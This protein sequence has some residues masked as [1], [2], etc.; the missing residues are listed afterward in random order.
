MEQSVVVQ[1][2]L[3]LRK[4]L[5]LLHSF[6]KVLILVLSVH[7]PKEVSQLTSISVALLPV[8]K[9]WRR[10]LL[11]K[12]N[13]LKKISPGK[14]KLVGTQYILRR[15]R[16][17][18]IRKLVEHVMLPSN[19]LPLVAWNMVTGNFGCPF[20]DHT[21]TWCFCGKVHA[22][23]DCYNISR[24]WYSWTSFAEQFIAFC[25]LGLIHTIPDSSH[26]GLLPMS[27]RPSIHTIPVESDML[28]IAIA[29]WDR[30][31]V[32]V[33]YTGLLSISDHFWP[34]VN[35][36][37]QY[38][39]APEPLFELQSALFSS[40]SQFSSSNSCHEKFL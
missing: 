4:E 38:I 16:I 40:V 27:D 9:Q 14:E 10:C 8:K 11:S 23:M 32:K 3:V 24:R 39:V 37:I 1:Q 36:R 20:L 7:R 35:A 6:L 5:H 28:R 12:G 18:W 22:W 21:S 30:S 19:P 26:I 33:V 25:Y 29:E 34:S 13:H 17:L 2:P 31:A 15:C